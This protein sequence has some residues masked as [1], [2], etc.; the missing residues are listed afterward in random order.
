MSV[1]GD[2]N[3]FYAENYEEIG[4][5]VLS[6][7]DKY[8]LGQRNDRRCR[9]CGKTEHE[10]TFSHDAHA[11]PELLGNKSITTNW[12]CD[13]CNNY[14]GRSI[15]NDL[16][17]WS[18]PMRTFA[19]IRGK[20]G[21]PTLKKS[22]SG[23]WRI[24]YDSASGLKIKS[25]ENDPFFELDEEKKVVRFELKR[26]TY[27]PIAVLKALCKI[28]LSL[29][30][31]NEVVYFKN[32]ISWVRDP[33]HSKGFV[34][35]VPVLYA[36]Q[37][38]P[39]PNDRIFAMLL[40]RRNDS[41]DLPYSTFVL[42]YGNETLQILV[43]SLE[44]DG[45]WLNTEFEFWRYPTQHGLVDEKYGKA[46]FGQFDFSSHEKVKSERFPLVLA[47]DELVKLNP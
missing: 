17:N 38:G 5:W 23:G 10:V 27:T 33:D 4:K 15:E 19:R 9:F 29:M 30:P 20:G 43:P 31:E 13:D 12:E 1:G 45:R 2:A 3:S 41:R 22:S 46:R 8:V 21:V 11:I 28:A 7:E 16:G 39:M 42:S 24:Q 40:R 47:F 37:P 36:F 25:Y 18:K 32:T 26:G 35:G 6:P 34:R 14:F 44:R